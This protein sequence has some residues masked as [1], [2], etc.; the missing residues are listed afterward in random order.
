MTGI[1][2]FGVLFLSAVILISYDIV[3]FL[4]KGVHGTIS[5]YLW[6]LSQHYPMIPFGFGLILGILSGH[7][8]WQMGC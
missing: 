4:T 3:L 8:F 6:S 2:F 5:W 1:V 7:L